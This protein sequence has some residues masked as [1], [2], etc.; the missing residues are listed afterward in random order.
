MAD[1]E[2]IIIEVDGLQQAVQHSTELEKD[3]AAIRKLAKDLGFDASESEIK[4]MRAEM[5]KFAKSLNKVQKEVRQLDSGFNKVDKSVAKTGARLKT[6]N[7][8]N[9]SQELTKTAGLASAVG[10]AFG[11]IIGGFASTALEFAVNELV[12]WINAETELERRIR[13][14]DEAMEDANSGLASATTDFAELSAVITDTTQSTEDR[15]GALEKLSEL[16]PEV[17]S[18]TEVDINNQEEL[19]AAFDDVNKQLI[20]NIARKATSAQLEELIGG[21]LNKEVELRKRLREESRNAYELL[22][23][24][25]GAYGEIQSQA[26]FRKRIEEEINEELRA[27]AG[28]LQDM[29]QADYWSDL[30]PVIQAL[31]DG[32]A[33]INQQLNAAFGTGGGGSNNAENRAKKTV[34]SLE[35]IELVVEALR[36]AEEEYLELSKDGTTESIDEQRQYVEAL[37]AQLK[38]KESI[39]EEEL[40]QIE[41]LKEAR[42]DLVQESI[43]AN[44]L[45]LRGVSK[46]GVTG[47]I[48]TEGFVSALSEEQIAALQ[49]YEEISGQQVIF[50]DKYKLFFDTER[51]ALT[52]QKALIE[53]AFTEYTSLL[54][55][56]SVTADELAAAKAF[57]F[58][59]G[60]VIPLSESVNRSIFELDQNVAELQAG[61]NKNEKQVQGILEKSAE[62]DEQVADN[63]RDR[64][65]AVREAVTKNVLR[66]AGLVN[67]LLDAANVTNIQ[68]LTEAAQR[69]IEAEL[70]KS[71][72]D[73]EVEANNYLTEVRN[74]VGEAFQFE[75]EGGVIEVSEAGLN[76]LF[77]FDP[78]TAARTQQFIEDSNKKVEL[79][80]EQRNQALEN[81]EVEAVDRAI[82]N[83]KNRN[84]IIERELNLNFERQVFTTKQAYEDLLKEDKEFFESRMELAGEVTDAERAGIIRDR[85]AVVDN[86][87]QTRDL[88]LQLRTDRYLEELSIIRENGGDVLLA[89]EEFYLERDK[90]IRKYELDEQKA[91]EDFSFVFDRETVD[92]QKVTFQDYLA[93]IQNLAQMTLSIINNVFDLFGNRQQRLID[94]LTDQITRVTNQISESEAKINSL[95]DDLEG[96]RSGRRDAV[97][98]GIELEKQRQE[99]LAEEKIRLDEKLRM[100]EKKLARQRKAQAITQAAVN[101]ALA[102]TNIAANLIDPTPVQAFKIAAITAQAA[103]TATQIGVIASQQFAEG[104]FTGEGFDFK[105]DTGHNVAGVVHNDE[106]VAPKWQVESPKYRPIIEYLESARVGGF[107]DGGFTTEPNFSNID[108]ATEVGGNSALMRTVLD[109]LETAQMLASRPIYTNVTDIAN[110]SGKVARRN[111]ATTIG[112]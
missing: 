85:D 74:L 6:F 20:A 76:A 64:E 47:E 68:E 110:V 13:V 66:D 38:A 70:D 50:D 97:L 41:E 72:T 108:V 98:R 63:I 40:K 32:A 80:V 92:E 25:S 107:A 77:E 73:V 69:E 51:R 93:E 24:S 95:E 111:R 67:Q 46:L 1:K 86:I 14:R 29:G 83:Y 23:A 8:R 7:V 15:N 79:A 39:T 84:A 49:A 65:N 12:E 17:N 10:G 42:K 96:K 60:I 87:R 82:R 48:F 2:Q 94:N 56:G 88:E 33:Q 34:E 99:E 71:I 90:I 37:R 104:G 9:L 62:I 109:S 26:A 11:G 55:T 27:Q 89:T 57:L 91:I 16:Y 43:N 53:Q 105:D 81:L 4:Q 106:W 19:A 36:E 75:V 44:S 100:E 18:L 59:K 22:L 112:R 45:A 31:S 5:D 28:S 30:L 102:I 3:L 61:L 54:S 103:L 52:E 101:G 21:Y 58:E 78:A 35:S